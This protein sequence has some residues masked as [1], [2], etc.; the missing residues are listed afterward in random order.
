MLL[1]ISLAVMAMSVCAGGYFKHKASK[2]EA[3]YDSA[4]MAIV[5]WEVS[6]AECNRNVT[7]QNQEIEDWAIR[8]ELQQGERDQIMEE[9]DY[10]RYERKIVSQ[11]VQ[12]RV[13]VVVAD[14]ECG[15]V[16]MPTGL[17][18]LFDTALATANQR[19]QD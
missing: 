13:Q 12:A 14:T 8:S 17:I 9:L 7:A 3:Q 19:M 4:R 1:K 5:Q 16:A 2:Y 6:N 18:G 11:E 10:E 15:A